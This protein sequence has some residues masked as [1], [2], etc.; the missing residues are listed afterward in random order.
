MHQPQRT[1]LAGVVVLA[2]LGAGGAPASGPPERLSPAEAQRLVDEV[3]PRV[4]Q[5]RGLTF[6]RPVPVEVVDDATAREHFMA[7]LHEFDQTQQLEKTQRVYELLGLIPAGADLLELLLGAV[8]EQAGG[9]YDPSS[10]AYYLLDDMPAAAAPIFTAH[11]LTHALEDQYF[12]LDGRLREVVENDDRLLARSAVHEGSATV[13]MGVYA[14]EAVMRGELDPDALQT[15]AQT[16]AGRAARLMSLP[17]VL[18]RQLLGPYVLGATFLAGDDLTSLARGFPEQAADRAMGEGPESTEQILHPE[19][20]WDSAERDEPIPLELGGAGE[21]LGGRWTLRGE[22][23]LGELTLG[24]LVGAPT[25]TH[26]GAGAFPAGGDWTNE[27]ASGWGGDRWELWER[28]RKAA[29]LMLTVWDSPADAAEFAEAL[30]RRKHLKWQVGDDRV[31][32]VAG[33]V[34]RKAR[35]LLARLLELGE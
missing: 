12:D 23:V 2:A 35:P 5:L 4:E 33:K 28:G 17:D 34:G 32:I 20:Y 25:P 26:A 27:A 6:K 16:E 22:G 14:V 15:L 19:K 18:L 13:L 21:I 30:P 3:V 29:V 9:Y 24:V 31:A 8:E 11:E 10:G 1:W 7:R